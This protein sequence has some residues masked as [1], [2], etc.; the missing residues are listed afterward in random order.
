VS[1]DGRFT[2]VYTSS[3]A[4][5][6]DKDTFRYQVSD[7][8]GGTA[9]ASATILLNAADS[10]ARPGP[11][12]SFAARDASTAAAGASTFAVQLDWLASGD[13]VQVVGYNVYRDGVLLAFVPSMAPP[14]AP[15][16]FVDSTVAPNATYRYRVTARD[17]ASE[18]NLSEEGVVSVTPSLRRNIQTGWG[19]GADS[20]WRATG[21]VGCHRAAAGG[22]TLFGTADV[23]MA[24]LVEDSADVVPR[25]LESVTPLRSLLL[26]KPLIKSDP[27]SCPHEGGTFLV[28]S[29]PR[30][31]LLLRW[32]EGAA[33]N[34]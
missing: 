3:L 15:V 11:V 32:I 31:Q 14:R 25:R 5:P 22:L 23:V 34:N 33:P 6:P 30:Y 16:G 8:H 2:Y 12:L 28:S 13:D 19:T 29:D 20:L 21:C 17:A 24:E 4:T 10:A 1:G 26:C 7:G 27:N 9:E 18:S